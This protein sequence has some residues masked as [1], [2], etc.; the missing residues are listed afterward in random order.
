[1]NTFTSPSVFRSV[2]WVGALSLLVRLWIGYS[3]PITGDE[4]Y[5]YWWGR[6][7]DWGY[8]DHPPMAGWWIALMLQLSGDS[9]FAIRMPAMVLPLALGASL[10]WGFSAIDRDKTA[11]AILL[12]WLTPI[13]WL[14]A[15]ITTDTPLIFWSVLSVCAL[16]RAESAST[17]TRGTVVLYIVSGL[18]LGLAFLSK[19]FAVLIGLAYSVYFL[20]ERRDRFGLFMVLVVAALPGPVINLLWNMDHGWANIM[21]NVFNR[22]QDA[23]FTWLNPALYVLTW[24]YLL[25]P[26]VA[27]VAWRQR[28]ALAVGLRQ[29]PLLKMVIV[30]PV[31]FF[32]LIA[33]KKVVGLHWLLNFY[34]FVFVALAFALPV[35]H[36][37]TCAKG[38]A[39]FLGLHLVVLAGLYS[40]QLSDWQ[41]TSFYAK[42]VRSYRTEA[43]LKQVTSP[44]TVLMTTSYTPAAIYGQTLKRYVPVFGTG[45]HHA[46]QDDLVVDFSAFNGKTIRILVSEAPNLNAYAPFF[47]SVSQWPIHQDGATFY[48]VEGQQFNAQ[49]YKDR[50]LRDVMA[51]YHQIPSWLPMTGCPI[52]VHYCQ[53]VRCAPAGTSP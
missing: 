9:T 20:S 37:K 18:C 7:P 11:W 52:C 4:A 27:W 41:N 35:Q 39:L 34:P 22:N 42:V 46:R 29:Q 44:D 48:V 36:I 8:Y 47:N 14:N 19:Y 5:F 30:V 25:T 28:A 6:Y 45:S 17:S 40:S 24:A 23:S 2:C 53:Q 51:S 26:A 33:V 15:L 50:V 21:F 16:A 49:V 13:H 43:L 1:M 31:V 12:L 10:W 3:F 38:L 32:A